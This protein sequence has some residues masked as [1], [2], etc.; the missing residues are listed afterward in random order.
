MVNCIA[1]DLLKSEW[2][3]S[4]KSCSLSVLAAYMCTHAQGHTHAYFVS[5]RERVYEM[6]DTNYRDAERRKEFFSF[7][8]AEGKNLVEL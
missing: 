8:L 4:L 3:E 5:Q 2:L 7:L 1:I 6:F